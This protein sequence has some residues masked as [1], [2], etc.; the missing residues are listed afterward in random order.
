MKRILCTLGLFSAAG[1]C[2]L[3]GQPPTMFPPVR[4]TREMVGRP[5]TSRLKPDTGF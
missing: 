2:L 1:F 3:P 5:T 4:G